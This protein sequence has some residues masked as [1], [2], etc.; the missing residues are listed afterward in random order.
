MNKEKKALLEKC[1]DMRFNFGEEIPILGGIYIVPTRYKHDSGYK[2]MHIVGHSP[3][4]TGKEERLYLIDTICDVVDFESYYNK[5]PINDLHIDISMGG[6]LH[7]WSNTQYMKC[8]YNVSACS[9]EMV[10]KK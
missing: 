1:V 10:G 5:I 6:I 8:H 3:R 4:K 7:V 9:F 2:I